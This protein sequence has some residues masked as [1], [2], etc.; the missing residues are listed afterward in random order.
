LPIKLKTILKKRVINKEEQSAI[1][2]PKDA[3]EGDFF[4]L[5]SVHVC[6]DSTIGYAICKLDYE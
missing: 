1:L 6:F 3:K 2:R 4:N 5:L